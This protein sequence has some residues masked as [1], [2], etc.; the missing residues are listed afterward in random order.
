MN[1][2]N[3]VH[4]YWRS[5]WICLKGLLLFLHSRNFLLMPGFER[6]NRMRRLIL[7][8]VILEILWSLWI[9]RKWV[10]FVPLLKPERILNIRS[11]Q[12]HSNQR[13]STIFRQRMDWQLCLCEGDS[14]SRRETCQIDLNTWTRFV[15][16][17]FR[18]EWVSHKSRTRGAGKRCE[19]TMEHKFLTS[20]GITNNTT[21]RWPLKLVKLFGCGCRVQVL[22]DVSVTSRC[23]RDCH[24]IAGRLGGR[25][26]HQQPSS[27]AVNAAAWG[28]QCLPLG[29]SFGA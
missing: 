28:D 2:V 16:D 17:F 11:A 8:I 21:V 25:R 9:C 26:W 14:D 23:R 20:D 29:P 7:V 24:A 10:V 1:R 6:C 5:P 19:A 15:Q 22:I 3:D 13:S 27:R 4:F 18:T 12:T